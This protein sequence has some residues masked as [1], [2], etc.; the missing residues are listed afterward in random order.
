LGVPRPLWSARQPIA[1]EVDIRRVAPDRSDP[2]VGAD[3]IAAAQLERIEP[4]LFR[5]I[6][7]R[8]LDREG[9]L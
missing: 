3:H 5:Q 8:A 2:V 1:A 4:E 6:V 7:D 9:C